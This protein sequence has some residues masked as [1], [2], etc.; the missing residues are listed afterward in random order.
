MVSEGTRMLIWNQQYDVIRLSR[1][2][3][4]LSSFRQSI[5]IV[6]QL[7]GVLA[8][9]GA[10]VSLLQRWEWAMLVSGTV[11]A[12]STVLSVTWNHPSRLAMIQSASMRCRDLEIQVGELWQRISS[13]TDAEALIETNELARR[14][15][16]ATK[17]V[18]MVGVAFSHRRNDKAAKDAREE[19]GWAVPNHPPVTAAR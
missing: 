9:M 2:Y 4:G 7:L 10:I 8:S 1:Y 15:E 16:D 6:S 3:T 11:I 5:Q 18:E 17:P 14:I 12:T 19:L 13:L